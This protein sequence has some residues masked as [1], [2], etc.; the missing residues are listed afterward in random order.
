MWIDY[1]YIRRSLT[2]VTSTRMHVGHYADVD[3]NKK[4]KTRFKSI[5]SASR[6]T[7]FFAIRVKCC[8]CLALLGMKTKVKEL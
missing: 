1:V 4:Q 6:K 5:I 7:S 2:I 8:F 3:K